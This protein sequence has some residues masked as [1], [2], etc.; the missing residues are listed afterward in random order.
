VPI[1]EFR[2]TWFGHILYVGVANSEPRLVQRFTG[3]VGFFPLT[4]QSSLSYVY[5][6]AR[7]HKDLTPLRGP[8]E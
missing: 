8:T 3:T 6:Q 2:T 7:L 1:S 4:V 5:M